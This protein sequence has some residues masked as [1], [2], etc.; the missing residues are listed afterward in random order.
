MI[1]FS[2]ASRDRA[3][4]EAGMVDLLVIGGGITGAGVALDAASRGLKP[5]LLERDDFVSGTSSRTTKLIH[6]G[7]R[8]LKNLEF[9]LVREAARERARLKRMAPHL[10]EPASFLVPVARRMQRLKLGTGLTLYDLLGGYALPGH[11][12]LSEREAVAELPPLAGRARGAY[13]YSDAKAD[14]CRL[15]FHVLKKAIQLGA[16]AAHYAP[17]R[18]FLM[19]DGVAVGV[20]VEDR[21]RG[22][23]IEIRARQ[24]VAAAGV[25]TDELLAEETRRLRPTKGIH[26]VVPR[27]KLG[28]RTALLIPAP[29]GRVIFAIPWGDRNILGTT[30][31]DYGGELDRPRATTEDVDYLKRQFEEALGVRIEN[32]DILATYAGLRPLVAGSSSNPSDVTRDVSISRNAAGVIV[33]VGGKLTTFRSMAR[34]IVNLARPDLRGSRTHRLDLFAPPA[35][36]PP[37]LARAYGS[38]S[39]AILQMADQTPIHESSPRRMS[40]IDYCVNAEACV[41]VADFLVRRTRAVLFD[42]ERGRLSA[43]PVARRLGELL[44]WDQAETGRQIEAF[45]RELELFT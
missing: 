29:D 34:R 45:E 27:A 16:R 11:R 36:A 31:T 40:E 2:R 38:E 24:I 44:G 15:T 14:D 19:R 12:Y 9:G 28:N 8:Y 13:L 22:R 18:D 35:S 26:L 6:G 10:I 39:T 37:D 23:D 42:P 32:S 25:W 4:D 20:R 43:E 41:S 1:D 21:L 3:L 5:L 33:V 30:D 17:V 7:L